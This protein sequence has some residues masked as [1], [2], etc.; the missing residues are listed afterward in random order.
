MDDELFFLS[1]TDVAD[2]IRRREVSPVELI[3]A[4][5]A[6]IERVNPPINAYVTLSVEQAR[7]AARE[8]ER[9]ILR[10]DAL[11]PLCGVPVH[12]KD[13]I[14]TAGIRTTYGSRVFEDHVPTEDAVLVARIKAA[15]A[16]V[17]GKTNLPEFASKGVCD[18]PLLGYG[19]NPWNLG[20]IPGGSSG[21]AA[22]AV[23]AGLGPLGI[24]NDVA[25]SI[26]VPAACCGVVGLKPSAGRVPNHPSGIPWDIAFQQGPIAR[27][28]GDLDL[29]LRVLSGPHD[30]DLLSLPPIAEDW[31]RRLDDLIRPWRFAWSPD[32]GVA[33]V[34][35]EVLEITTTAVEALRGAGR[36]DSPKL[37]LGDALGVFTVVVPLLRAAAVAP[38]VE[39]WA[40]KMDPFVADYY[41]R[42]MRITTKE[43]GDAFQ[44]RDRL[45]ASVATVLRDHDFIVTPTIACVPWE[46]DRAFPAL[47]DSQPLAN[48]RDWLPFTY[49]FNF[50]GHPAVS[51]PAGWTRDGLPVGLQIVGTRFADR[52]VLAAARFLERAR[53]WA[54]RRPPMAERAAPS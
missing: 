13:N 38:F 35:P 32:L 3:E 21:G 27:T 8:A 50:T 29:A 44:H 36:V 10:G 19:R 6:R 45:A 2:R 46:Y 31:D 47:I 15:G 30:L 52:E 11:P 16:I 17:V 48:W 40:P 54:H 53:P 24:G 12:L 18:S 7:T 20:R 43:L 4:L 25:G 42:G 39:Q 14:E 33:R 5:L 26:R 41:R 34:D 37:N 1:A 51:V 23:A 9:A 49:P 28:V 22:A